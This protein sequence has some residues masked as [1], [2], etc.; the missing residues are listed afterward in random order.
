MPKKICICT[1]SGR[2][3]SAAEQMLNEKLDSSGVNAYKYEYQDPAQLT[4]GAVTALKD[5]NTVIVACPKEKFGEVKF[6]LLKALPEKPSRSRT[7]VTSMG[8]NI[9]ASKS[10]Y[11]MHTAV[12]EKARIFPSPDGYFSGF[13]CHAFNG[14]LAF[15]P[16][17]D[18]RTESILNAG[19]LSVSSD[20]KKSKAEEFREQ[21]KKITESGKTVAVAVGGCSDALLAAT[22]TVP[23]SEAAFS[24][25]AIKIK[26]NKNESDESFYSRCASEARKT[27]GT[28][29]GICISEVTDGGRDGTYVTV[30]SADGDSA[31]GAKVYSVFGEEQK[32]LVSAALIKLIKMLDEPVPE[33][34][35]VHKK[36]TE[37]KSKLPLLIVIIAIAA[38]LIACGTVAFIHSS[39]TSVSGAANKNI[40]EMVFNEDYFALRGGIGL[41]DYVDEAVLI[42]DYQPDAPVAALEYSA[43]GTDP[44]SI[45]LPGT[46]STAASS[47]PG[48]TSSILTTIVRTAA[49]T[50]AQEATGTTAHPSTAK[51]TAA[52]KTTAAPKTTAG[53]KATKPTTAPTVKPTVPKTTAKPV[54]TTKES[55]PS[56]T[57]KASTGE[58]KFVF[59]VYGW[60]HGVG[61]SQDGAIAMARNGKG[62]EE[63]LLNYYNGVSIKTDYGAPTHIKYGG[64]SIPIV[65][66]L[67]RTA[68]AEIGDDAP[69]EALKAQI[70]CIYTFAKYYKFDVSKSLHAYRSSFAYKG[71]TVYKACLAVLDMANEEDTA[72][73]KYV[74][75]NGSPAFTCY[76][77]SSPGHTTSA[78]SVWGGNYPYL[79]GG[80]PSPEKVDAT[81]VEIT[82]SEMKRLIESYA[83]D[84]GKNI[85]LG[86][87]PSTWLEII[88]HDSAYNS[89]TGYVETMRV[90]NYT[91]KGN[92]FRCYVADY[93]LRSQCYSF[94]YVD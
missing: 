49:S 93:K 25:A 9:P 20:K 77:A 5:G 16:L 84:N 63:I 34:A 22:A 65:E 48:T 28:D 42:E 21:V 68:A 44:V 88:S 86:S 6:H 75:Y 73:A 8:D 43:S 41:E 90:G 19:V 53:A 40:G 15:V 62:Y 2:S 10:E 29:Q 3:P 81:T 74:S 60:G 66:Y 69:L 37:K 76:F 35:S 39:R 30:A 67:C 52:A 59:H 82:A 83:S 32:V 26:R 51:A 64:T 85:V 79:T 45:P 91:M 38:A 61:L 47:V 18:E 12:P 1:L 57:K 55:T 11:N 92:T 23:G 7:I 89:H 58:G 17:D 56:T 70:V 4:E 80:S 14:N 27:A 87:D 54:T 50:A 71:T 13:S 94:E 72:N 24:P 46:Q 36:K 31:K 33:N 78:E